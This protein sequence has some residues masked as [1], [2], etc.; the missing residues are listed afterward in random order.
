MAVM[1]DPR[2]AVALEV[3]ALLRDG[4]SLLK[5]A[6]Q[7]F[8]DAADKMRLQ[9]IAEQDATTK[10]PDA[11]NRCMTAQGMFEELAGDVSALRGKAI[12][13]H[14]AMSL[15]LSLTFSDADLVIY[16]TINGPGGGRR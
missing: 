16:S 8:A 6:K 13:Y 9:M 5:D 11:A 10:V 7:K 14:S 12:R 2:K 1:G 3:Q 4:K 15:D